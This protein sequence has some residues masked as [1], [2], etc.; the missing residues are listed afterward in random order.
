MKDQSPNKLKKQEE[1]IILEYFTRAVSDFPKG[2]IHASE[3]PDFIV[4]SGPKKRIGIEITRLTNS[5]D[6]NSEH[7]NI[8]VD[9]LEK[10]ICRIAKTIFEARQPTPLFVDLY[11][12]E[13]IR[14]SEGEVPAYAGMIAEDIDSS[15]NSFDP[16]SPFHKQIADPAAKDIL[17]FIHI[18]YL[19][20]V[21]KSFWDNNGAYM[22][23]SLTPENIQKTIG[24][25][26]E[27]LMLYRKS[28]MNACWL[29]IYTDNLSRNHP[30]NIHNQLDSWDLHSEFDR[31]YLF[32]MMDLKAYRICN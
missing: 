30:F 4:A 25:K 22:I 21:D 2:K 20:S 26:E 10:D 29:L 31:V 14:I 17:D 7:K 11:F 9:N 5:F 13:G 27:K 18:S 32:E 19:P 15:I 1:R 8:Q 28:K 24:H 3:S 12:R 23:P 16:K 6:V